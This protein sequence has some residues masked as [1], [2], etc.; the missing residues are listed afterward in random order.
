MIFLLRQLRMRMHPCFGLVIGMLG[1]ALAPAGA[2]V[3][4]L[5]ELPDGWWLDAFLA[6]ELE[7]Q[8]EHGVRF[9]FN[10]NILV[11]L[12][13]V[14]PNQSRTTSCQRPFQTLT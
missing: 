9:R 3:S 5:T 4:V 12:P 6:D 10:T 14:L 11:H 2:A 7:S 8:Q 1:A 13:E